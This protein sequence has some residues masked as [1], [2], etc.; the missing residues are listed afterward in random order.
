MC[1]E[2]SSIL[3]CALLPFY[4]GLTQN[5]ARSTPFTTIQYHGCNSFVKSLFPEQ[6]FRFS[7]PVTTL[8]FNTSVNSI[9]DNA[10]YE[11]FP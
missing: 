8:K 7:H 2:I 10:I 5:N 4:S 1:T 3:Q 6:V 11:G 9:G